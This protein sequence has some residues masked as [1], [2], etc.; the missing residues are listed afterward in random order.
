M[1]VKCTAKIEI[2]FAVLKVHFVNHFHHVR[3]KLTYYFLKY[4]LNN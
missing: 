1:M 3:F 4:V 2:C